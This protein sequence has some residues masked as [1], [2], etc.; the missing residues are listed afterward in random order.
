MPQQGPNFTLAQD[1]RHERGAPGPDNAVNPTDVGIEYVTVQE[2]ERC[3]GLILGSRRDIPL[4]HQ[5]GEEGSNLFLAHLR[6]MP[7]AKEQDKKANPVNVGLFG[8]QAVA[9]NALPPVPYPT[10]GV[11]PRRT[12]MC[13]IT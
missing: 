1:D 12:S 9:A 13:R 3:E 4:D 11:P 2:Q 5:V 7:F 10:V 6:R 8:T